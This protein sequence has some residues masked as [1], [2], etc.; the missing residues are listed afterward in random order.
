M[1]TTLS[2]D[3]YNAP[4]WGPLV[5]SGHWPSFRSFWS[6]VLQLA[7]ADHADAVV[8]RLDL[9]E[10][11]LGVEVGG[12]THVMDPQSIKAERPGRQRKR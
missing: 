6:A 11:C 12:Q 2:V 8:Y 10:D 1:A 7:T 9:G 3:D 5:L 4:D